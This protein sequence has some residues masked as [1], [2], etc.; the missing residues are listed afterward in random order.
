LG[1]SRQGENS[2]DGGPATQATLVV[3]GALDAPGALAVNPVDGDIAFT[4]PGYHVVRVIGGAT[5]II[6][7][8][9]GAPHF[10]GDN[11]PAVLALFNAANGLAA[12]GAGN[13]YLADTI[14]D[15]IRKIAPS[16]IVTT[17][18]GNGI[19]GNSGDEGEATQ[20][21]IAP[22]QVAADQTGNVYFIN[23]TGVTESVRMVDKNGILHTIAGGGV[24]SVANGAPALSVSLAGLCC[25]AIGSS[26][27]LYIG[28]NLQTYPA[29]GGSVNTNEILKVSSGAVSIAAGASFIVD[30]F[31]AP[32]PALDGAPA[33]GANIEFVGSVAVDSSGLLYFV[34]ASVTY[35]RIRM[36]DASG[37]L[38]T[39]S[40]IVPTAATT[41]PLVQGPAKAAQ[42]YSPSCLI[43]D[44]ANNLYFTNFTLNEGPQ[45]AVIDSSGILTPVGGAPVGY[46]YQ[47]TTGGDGGDSLEA[48]FASVVG[49]ALDSS[50]NIYV[51][52]SGVYVRKLSPYNPAN[53]PPYLSAGGVIGAGASVPAVAAVSPNGDASI[54]GANFGVTHTL[55]AAD[56]VNGSVPTNLAGVCVSFGGIPAAILGV[57]PGQINVQVPALP[58][59]AV[60]VQVTINCG[61]AKAIVSNFSGVAVQ[62]A[63]PEFF[64]FLPDPT[65]GKNPIAAVNAITGV[66]IGVSGLLPGAIFAPAKAGDIV[67]AFGTGFGATSPSFGLGVLPGAAG[68]LATPYTL[69]FAGEPLPAANILY[70]GVAP[71]CAGL[72]QVNFTVPSGTPS[73]NQPLI[74]TMGGVSSPPNA[75]LTVQ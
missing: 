39:I 70:A 18:A 26:G 38:A 68:A 67:E 5:N 6:Q 12:D 47:E 33:V 51:L 9:A 7:T 72:Y 41:T 37:K 35:G 3:E 10:G 23:N 30:Q 74:M 45:I 48:G 21:Q 32:A 17:I 29:S 65:G 60:T 66:L 62:S 54:Y 42:L 71:C 4:E 53:P 31:P 25:L 58:P 24:A 73:G 75:F 52:D 1:E 27:D 13:V 56:L 57:Y 44:S 15:R 14:N 46:P 2:G 64:T 63:S 55:T 8:V 34:E 16:G 20:A 19:A 22:T 11:G 59:G 50:G 61:H 43:F 28:Q 49:L 69:T 40:G 36:V